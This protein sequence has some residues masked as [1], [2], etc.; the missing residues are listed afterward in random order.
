MA[1]RRMSA[2]QRKAQLADKAKQMFL[3]GGYRG[4]TT[5]DVAAAAGVSEALVVKHFGSKEELFRHSMIDPLLQMLR[6]AVRREPPAGPDVAERWT[7]LH[8]FYRAWSVVV[9][10]EGPLLWAVLREAQEFPDAMAS[11]AALFRSHIVQVAD[12]IARSLE[13]ENFREFDVEVATYMGLAGATI[14]GLMGGDPG[15]FL[16]E[17][18]DL[19]FLGILTPAGR[20]E[21]DE[22]EDRLGRGGRPRRPTPSQRKD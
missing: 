7:S 6:E 21:L 5:K 17:V 15:P 20:R 18:V 1:R 22:A 2:E 11:I 9:R 14:A 19:I 12:K 10:D 4:T 13:R 8:D 16:D 3:E